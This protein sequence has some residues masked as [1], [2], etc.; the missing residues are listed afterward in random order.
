[1]RNYAQ[2]ALLL[3]VFAAVGCTNWERSAFQSLSASKAAVDSAQAAYEVSASAPCPPA[4]ATPCIPHTETAYDTINRAKAAQKTAV[5]AMVTYET[6][7]AASAGQAA[8][9]KAQTDVETALAA[10]PVLITDVKSLYAK[11]GK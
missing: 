6:A 9:D 10:L 2:Y 5:D 1:M 4:S 3:I 11:G 7:K 8:L